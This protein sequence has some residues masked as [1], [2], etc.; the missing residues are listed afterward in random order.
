[1]ASFMRR[2]DRAATADMN[3]DQ[4]TGLVVWPVVVAIS[5]AVGPWPVAVW[6]LW[7]AWSRQGGAR[8]SALD[9][10]ARLLAAATATLPAE[11]R[12]WGQ[13]MA[14]EL[15]QVPASERR[16]RWR[17]AA[18][19]T[20]AAS[21]PPGG[22]RAAVGVTGALAVV[23]TTGAALVARTALPAGRVFAPLFVGLLG[24]LATLA[25]AR[26]HR[27][28][29]AGPGRAGCCPTGTAGA[30]ASPWPSPWWPASC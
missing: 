18:G 4:H 11:R 17:F 25:V 30:S 26:S 21:F 6:L 3:R 14:A 10:P 15:A 19:C 27:D 13:A 1:M 28:G 24:G 7:R 20:R 12:D 5:F 8:L 29:R 16:A 22:T 9:G 23:A 2:W